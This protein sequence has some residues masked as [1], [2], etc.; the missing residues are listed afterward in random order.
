MPQPQSTGSHP[1]SV[2]GIKPADTRVHEYGR[3]IAITILICII[4]WEIY[5]EVN[6]TNDIEDLEHIIKQDTILY[7]ELMELDCEARAKYV[8]RLKSV[9]NDKEETLL[10]KLS[11][12][13]LVSLVATICSEYIIVGNATKPLHT[14]SKTILFTAWNLSLS[15]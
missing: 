1:L 5:S 14:V 2:I 9:F 10:E 15:S 11:K 3:I 13:A 12:T 7:N 8:K 6:E 4:G